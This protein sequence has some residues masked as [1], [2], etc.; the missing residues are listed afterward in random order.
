MC[1]LTLR[2]RTVCVIGGSGFVGQTVVQQLHHAGY[3][4]RVPT[5]NIERAKALL[6]LPAVD[7]MEADVHDPLQLNQVLSGTDAV[8]NLAG[9]LHERSAKRA[10][11]RRVH[12]EL[13]GKIVKACG[14]LGIRRLLQMSALDANLGAQSAYARS[15]AQGEDRLRNATLNLTIFRPSV[16]FGPDDAFL[17]QFAALLRHLPF[18]PLACGDA[19]LQ[20]VYVQDVARTFVSSLEN[21]LTFG[22]TYELCGPKIY[23]LQQLVEYVS[24]LQQRRRWIFSLGAR[25]SFFQ[26]WLLENL[27]GKLMTRDDYHALLGNSVCACNFPAVFGFKP[28]ALEAVAAQY[29]G[30]QALSSSYDLWRGQVRRK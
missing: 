20:P 30:P 16:I 12:V 23:T 28:T 7:V 15:K 29:L 11:F 9:I 18:L 26:A 27:P 10:D 2:I 14:K 21:S 22:Q 25:A 24:A 4:I 6:V 8:I 19:K 3:G 1:P 13:P 17:N 5:H